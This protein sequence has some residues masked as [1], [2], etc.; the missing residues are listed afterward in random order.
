MRCYDGRRPLRR[1]IA[2]TMSQAPTDATE[3]APV[4]FVLL[5]LL[6]A[7]AGAV[8]A[9]GIM[10]LNDVFLSFMSGNSTTLAVSLARGDWPH[11]RLIGLIIGVFVAGAACGQAVAELSG[12]WRLPVV[13]A[14]VTALLCLSLID[15]NTGI[16]AMTFAMGALNAAMQHAG[17][18]AVSITFV[19]GALVR[20][21][22]GLGALLTGRSGGWLWLPQAVPW[23]GLMTGAVLVT[24]GSLQPGNAINI[25][26]PIF[27]GVLTVLTAVA[28]L[29]A[30]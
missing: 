11:A 2:A 17:K 3:R 4:G 30:G 19:T 23:T 12:R 22:Q 8:D 7:L 18:V 29:R 26:L 20:F 5:W 14:L 25:M 13:V 9:R 15:T 24:L 28:V 6:A 27:S 16:L 10:L 21:G 1:R